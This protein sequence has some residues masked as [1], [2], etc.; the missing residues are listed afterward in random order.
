M[1]PGKGGR[2][3]VVDRADV[4][5]IHAVEPS[6]ERC[7]PTSTTRWVCQLHA[8]TSCA[9]SGVGPDPPAAPPPGWPWTFRH[10]SEVIDHLAGPGAFGGDPADAFE[11][12][13]PS[14]PG[15]GYSTPTQPDMNFWKIADVGL[16]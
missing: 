14:L 6:S 9:N 10:R 5:C 7:M 8:F 12:I 3:G 2:R 16:R 15:D 11:E 1:T 13:V 4:A